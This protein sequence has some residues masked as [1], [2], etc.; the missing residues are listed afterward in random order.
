[1]HAALHHA[2]LDLARSLGCDLAAQGAQPGSVSERNA[3]RRGFTIAYTRAHM[4]R[5]LAPA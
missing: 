4:K 3:L 2:R 5:A 1:V